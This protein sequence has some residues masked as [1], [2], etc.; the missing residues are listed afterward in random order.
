MA[1]FWQNSA[2]ILMIVGFILTWLAGWSAFVYSRGK[3]D[4]RQSSLEERI[5]RIEQTHVSDLEQFKTGFSKEMSE[6]KTSITADISTLFNAFKDSDGDIK[7][8]T[9]RRHSQLCAAYQKT[10]ASD[11]EHIKNDL[12]ELKSSMKSV[13]DSLLVLATSR[14]GIGGGRADGS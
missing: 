7:Y 8:L 11:T 1:E 13:Q 14:T 6:F 5:D 3:I 10:V 4:G 9:E 2:N 12:S